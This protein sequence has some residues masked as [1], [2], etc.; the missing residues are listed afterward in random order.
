MLSAGNASSYKL[1]A[2]AGCTA[3]SHGSLF[4]VWASNLAC[5]GRPRIVASNTASVSRAGSIGQDDLVRQDKSWFAR[6]VS[7]RAI[8]ANNE[9]RIAS[10]TDISMGLSQERGTN[11]V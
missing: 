6:L 8:Q 5:R 9:A 10:S 1:P 4:A 2:R 3:A 7:F 11:T